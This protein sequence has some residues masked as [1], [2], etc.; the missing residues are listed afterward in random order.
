MYMQGIRKTPNAYKEL[1]AFGHG[2]GTLG[3]T[4]T[5]QWFENTDIIVVMLTNVGRMHSGLSPT[6][7]SLFYRE[8]LLPAVMRYLGR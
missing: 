8:V 3:F 5:M 1:T 2:G 4:A 7:P 6:P